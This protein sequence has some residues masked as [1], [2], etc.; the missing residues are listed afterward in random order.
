MTSTSQATAAQ[1]IDKTL[2]SAYIQLL[3]PRVMA[4]SI[5]TALI[6]MLAALDE[7]LS[8]LN[9]I[10]LL[11]I[12]IGAGGSAALN[13]ALEYKT[14]TLMKRTH[15]RPIPQGLIP[16]QEALI[17]G[18]MLS[19]SSIFLMAFLVGYLPAFLLGLTILFYGYFY[20]VLLKPNTPYNIVWG[21]IAGA[22][23]PV[24]GWFSIIQTFSW[25]PV[26]LFGLIFF[27]TLP[28]FWALA[29]RFKADYQ[30]ARIPML[31]NTHGLKHTLKQINLY[32][33]ITAIFG[34][35]PYIINMRG[36]ITTAMAALISI[37]FIRTAHQLK[38]N[39]TSPMAL[40]K[41][42]IIYLFAMHV[43]L[44]FYLKVG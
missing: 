7:P 38:A 35:L 3:K 29:I 43:L 10:A 26:Y 4:L 40:F 37:K 32:T 18:V 17:L 24:I 16:P 39:Q 28:H 6:G 30:A 31:P 1:E 21:G 44:I 13:M 33:W 42:S 34:L 25:V 2:L 12:A 9:L 14:D 23:P 5:F 8:A 19:I 41:F 22:L 36:W 11:L 27:W 15:D 20:T